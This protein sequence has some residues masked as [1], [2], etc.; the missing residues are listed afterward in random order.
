MPL[1]HLFGAC[2]VRRTAFVSVDTDP[3]EEQTC[4]Q[5]RRR[6]EFLILEKMLCFLLCFDLIR[7]RLLWVG[8]KDADEVLILPFLDII[9]TGVHAVDVSFNGIPLIADEESGFISSSS[10]QTSQLQLTWLLSDHA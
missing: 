2:K 9:I 7:L 8:S 10:I 3:Y 1:V 6:C 4:L 5:M